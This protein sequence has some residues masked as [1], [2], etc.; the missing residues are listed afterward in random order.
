MRG[1]I[2]KKYRQGGTGQ[3]RKPEMR[4]SATDTENRPAMRLIREAG[5]AIGCH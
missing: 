2:A 5:G 1:N 4:S 3:Q